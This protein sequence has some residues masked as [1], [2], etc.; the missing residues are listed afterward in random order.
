VRTGF[1][2][3][4]L[5][6]IDYLEDVGLEGRIILKWL[7]KKWDEGT[8]DWIDLDRDRDKWRTVVDAVMNFRVS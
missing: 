1:W 5:R 2:R 8:M 3:G 4:N 7:F 6:E